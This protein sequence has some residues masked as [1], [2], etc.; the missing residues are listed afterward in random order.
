MQDWSRGRGRKRE[1]TQAER[2]ISPGAFL[3]TRVAE[4]GMGMGMGWGLMV[5]FLQ[6]VVQER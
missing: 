1:R 4:D 2:G 3:W 5:A 6:S